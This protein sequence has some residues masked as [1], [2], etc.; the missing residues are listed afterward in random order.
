MTLELI[1]WDVQHGSATYIKT[2]NGKHIVYDLGTGSYGNGNSRFSPLLQLKNHWDVEQL[3]EVIISHPHKDHIE[4][5]L[6]FDELSP[7]VFKRPTHLS[8]KEVLRDIRDEDRPIFDKYF[9]I[10]DEYTK[11]VSTEKSPLSSQNNG[12]ADI[13]A[14][15]STS[16]SQS[17][18]NNHSIVLS[19]SYA[20]SKILLTGDNES[21]SWKELLEDKHFRTAIENTDIL[22]APHHGRIDGFYPDLF[23]YFKP[24]LTIISD[25][26]I[27]DTSATERYNKVTDGWVVHHRNRTKEKRYCVT[28]RNDGSIKVRLGINKSDKSPFLSVEIA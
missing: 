20:N 12:G 18:I 14:F 3:D 10:N 24:S 2:P 13:Q 1:C 6:N 11:P 15:C 22:L 19:I 16:C 4:D 5:I 9:E 21:P 26:H 7:K 8:K 23:K 27:C 25:G 17:N 28:T